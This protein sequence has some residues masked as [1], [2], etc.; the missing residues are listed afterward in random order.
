MNRLS[1]LIAPILACSILLPLLARGARE[2]SVAGLIGTVLEHPVPAADFTLTD[3]HGAPFQMGNTKGRVVVLTFIY[4]HCGD[5]CP[6][7]SLKIKSAVSILGV[8]M[9]RVS[10]V[11]VTTDPKRD[12]QIVTSAYSK[13]MG[14]D[15]T[16]HFLTGPLDTL[17]TVWANY[18]IGVEIDPGFQPEGLPKTARAEDTKDTGADAE[19]DLATQGLTKSDLELAGN[20]IDQFSGGYEVAHSVPFWIIDKAGRVR[21]SLGADALPADI[22]TDVRLLL[23]S[24]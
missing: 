7:V 15:D 19:A 5:T 8:D 17:K 3:Q 10:F 6:Y 1:V 9:D 12:V 14:L 16:W 2:Q 4:T 23:K 20:I 21:A 22:V 24:R 18:G 13:A 11:A